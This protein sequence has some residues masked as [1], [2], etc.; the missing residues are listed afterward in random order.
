MY[1]FENLHHRKNFCEMN[2]SSIIPYIPFST[3]GPNWYIGARVVSSTLFLTGIF[4]NVVSFKVF[5]QPSMKGTTTSIYLRA[6]S[7]FDSIT[8]T[9]WFVYSIFY[10][11]GFII[12]SRTITFHIHCTVGPYLTQASQ[13]ISTTTLCLMTIDRSLY[14]IFPTKAQLIST[15]KKTLFLLFLTVI[16][17]LG[18][19]L[20]RIFANDDMIYIKNPLDKWSDVLICT[21]SNKNVDWYDQTI[22]PLLE[23]AATSVLPGCIFIIT[24]CLIL[25][26]V[27]AAS[28]KRKAMTSKNQDKNEDKARNSSI[29]LLLIST[30]FIVTNIPS[31]WLFIYVKYVLVATPDKLSLL[32]KVAVICDVILK[33]NFALNFIFYCLS[34]KKF[35]QK[36]IEVFK[37]SKNKKEPTT[38]RSEISKQK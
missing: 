27:L 10:T 15:K 16:F 23:I 1:L 19:C 18:A 34:G 35:R 25:K 4:G 29:I 37:K 3:Q 22:A 38:A 8:L 6:L 13:Q 9:T 30:Y 24:N 32:K 12:P 17:S 5:N 2:N 21:K 11:Y 26:A 14:I 7:I 36:F 28:S 33:S 20:I 31:I